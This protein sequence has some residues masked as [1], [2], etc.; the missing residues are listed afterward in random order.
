MPKLSIGPRVRK[1]PYFD[2]TLRHGAKAFTIYNHMFMPTV[3]SDPVSEYWHLVKDVA[4]WDVGCERQVEITGPD[5]AR[6]I[7]LLT[8]RNLSTC[9]VN[10][11]RYVVVTAEDG[12][13]INDAIL[14]R[15]A[16]NHFW[17]SPGDGDVLL[18]AQG[19]AA[20]TNMIRRRH[21]PESWRSVSR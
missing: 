11:C 2:A 6:F 3:Y 16:E 10:R 19:I 8:P 7:Q 4:L 5:A 14:L 1:S 21:L 13:I 9:P 17:L 12:G 15:L 20:S 18:W